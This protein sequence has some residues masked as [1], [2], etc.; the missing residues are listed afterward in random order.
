L[1]FLGDLL[2]VGGWS[3]VA[4]DRDRDAVV[5]GGDRA[6]DR[7]GLPGGRRRGQQAASRKC[8]DLIA[9]DPDVLS[10]RA[11]YQRPARASV[12]MRHA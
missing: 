7:G 10:D 5:G 3:A 11:T 8:A 9:F 12:G 4:G 2:D 6:V 1:Q